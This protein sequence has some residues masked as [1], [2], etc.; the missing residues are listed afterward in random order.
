MSAMMCDVLEERITPVV[1]NAA[2]NAGG[3]MLKVIE[4]NMKYGTLN[5]DGRTRTLTLASA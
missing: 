5:D 1:A 2:V 3:K 4:L